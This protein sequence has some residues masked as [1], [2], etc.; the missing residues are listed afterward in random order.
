[1]V[2]IEQ[3]GFQEKVISESE[4]KLIPTLLVYG[5]MAIDSFLQLTSWSPY[6]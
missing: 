1:M 3:T 2:E 4:L 5:K 6:G